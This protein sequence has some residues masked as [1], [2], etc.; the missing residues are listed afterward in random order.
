MFK[1]VT[2]KLLAAGIGVFFVGV[3]ATIG[4]A[5][6]IEHTNRMS[7]CIS[8]HEMDFSVY[9]EYKKSAHFQN[10]SGVRA[11]CSDCHVPKDDLLAKLSRKLFAAND[12]YHHI[13]GTVDTPEK[14]DGKRLDLAKRVWAAMKDTNS[15]ECRS[16]HSFQAMDPAKQKQRSTGQHT[17][18]QESGETCIDCHKGIVHKPVHKE[19]QKQEEPASFD[20]S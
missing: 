5:K 16:C 10:R 1:G 8:C 11:T 7:F 19:L 13:L 20:L 9:Q 2:R 18:A 14:F 3:L 15:R 12:V 6:F 17:S 4:A